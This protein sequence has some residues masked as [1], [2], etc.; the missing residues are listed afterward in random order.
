MMLARF[1]SLFS[2]VLLSIAATGA[3]IGATAAS[4]NKTNTY[5]E[6][7]AAGAANTAY[8]MGAIYPA[9]PAGATIQTIGGATYYLYNGVWFSPSYGANGVYY[10]VVPVP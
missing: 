8:A 10:R 3:L 6:G 9:L 7:Y 1:P 2:A 4:V 5:A